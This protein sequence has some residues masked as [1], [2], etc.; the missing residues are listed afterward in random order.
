MINLE[1]EKWNKLLKYYEKDKMKSQIPPMQLDI[2]TKYTN[3]LMIL[4]SP[5]QSKVLYQLY[6]NAINEGVVL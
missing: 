3:G 2:L 5:K 1:K 6:E 4:P